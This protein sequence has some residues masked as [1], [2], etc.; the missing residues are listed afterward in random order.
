VADAG[1]G[2]GEST[3]LVRSVGSLLRHLR[4][5]AH[6]V[7]A[8][9]AFAASR[10]RVR[11]LQR[12]WVRLW[13][14]VRP[15]SDLDA[16]LAT[17]H[18]APLPAS[19]PWAPVQIGGRARLGLVVRT[20]A[21]LRFRTRSQVGGV[22]RAWAAPVPVQAGAPAAVRVRVR[23]E[24]QGGEPVTVERAWPVPAA[25][26]PQHWRRLDVPVGGAADVHREVE[27]DRD[28]VQVAI[29][30]PA[31]RWP[32][33]A[34]EVR[35][36]LRAFAGRLRRGGARDAMRWARETGRR[37]D[38]GAR[39][40]QWCR[41]HTPGPEALAA[42]AAR[43]PA[44]PVQ[45]R[46]SIVTPVFNTDPAW[47]EEYFRSVLAQVYPHWELVVSDDGSTR[48]ETLAT[49]RKYAAHQQVRVVW[50]A[51]NGGISAAT[52]AALR[53]ATGDYVA[54]MDHDD[55]LLPHALFRMAEA[56]ATDPA[57]DLLYSDEDKLE[58]DG[59][60]SDAYFKP[61]WS[62]DLFLSSMYACHLLVI[63]RAHVERAGG[64]RSAFDGS[65]DYDLVLRVLDLD[66]R[67]AHVP[68]VLYHWRKIPQSASSSGAAKPWAH[69]AGIRALQDYAD[70][71]QLAAT[72]EETG[73]PGLYRMRYAVRGTPLVTVVV[74]V[75]AG[76]EEPAT[77]LLDR[78]EAATWARREIVVAGPAAVL[79]RLSARLPAGA[80]AV[81]ADGTPG[82][83][84]NVATAAAAGAHLLFLDPRIDPLHDDW[85]E[86][87]LE[88]AQRPG[89]GAVGAKLFY[90]DGRLRHAGLVVGA[91]GLARASFDGF[92]GTWAGYFSSAN[93]IRNCG[94]VSR[95]CLMTPAPVFRAVGGWDAQLRA[96]GLEVDYA[97]R[98]RDA[99]HR[100]VFTPYARLTDRRAPAPLA[101]DAADRA[102][103]AARWGRGLDRDPYYNQHFVAGSADHDLPG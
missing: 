13:A 53:Q 80:R 66:P 59:S 4:H 56:I 64:F 16:T 54:L 29:G 5:P 96:D 3:T 35:G 45:P 26:A 60:R 24:P 30:D 48:P 22:V 76:D 93:C 49:L 102:R 75:A 8:A 33:P 6:A 61:D 73:W 38:E 72:V 65:Q 74:A 94:A 41:T 83:V 90:P 92:A 87:L 103:L 100:V 31:V 7:R 23:V 1:E 36:L 20:P 88:H 62:P 11:D 67:I 55:V 58:L 47:L 79:A 28:G 19:L 34:G 17:S 101:P 95:A 63:R 84:L 81:P 98:V 18:G 52:Q 99:G 27:A 15:L 85:I 21:T 44:L 39:Y 14:E 37:T 89:I 78:L 68:D 77:R 97:L 43:V 10:S 71:N 86:P 2:R 12:V 70:R 40:R 25:W 91:G 82:H 32:R 57:L 9:A 46:F 51:V 69:L 50:N 42:M